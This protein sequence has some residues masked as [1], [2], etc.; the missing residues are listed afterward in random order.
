MKIDTLLTPSEMVDLNALVAQAHQAGAGA[1][2]MFIEARGLVLIGIVK[3]GQLMTWFA[4]PAHS[5]VEAV[6]TERVVLAGITAAGLA[7][8]AQIATDAIKKASIFH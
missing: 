5:L 4:A 2:R 6:M 1:I 7:A 8:S 3:H